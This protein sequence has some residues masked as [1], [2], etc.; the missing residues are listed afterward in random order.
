MID[1]TLITK[2]TALGQNGVK[3]FSKQLVKLKANCDI[4]YKN[5]AGTYL[6]SVNWVG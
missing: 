2:S 6:M 5:A 1:P 4:I 3:F